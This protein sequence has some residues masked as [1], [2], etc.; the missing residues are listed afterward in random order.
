MS[1]IDSGF[2]T[3]RQ[4][5]RLFYK[6]WMPHE[7]P[8]KGIVQIAHGMRESTDYYNEFCEML[9][10]QGYGAFIH[11]AR[12]HGQTAGSPYSDD[13]RNNAGDIGDN[14]I[15]RMVE[16][17]AEIN[18]MLHKKYQGVPVFLLGHSMGSVLARLYISQYGK[19]LNGVI[20]S[21]TAALWDSN[22]L[23]G[24]L[25]VAEEEA[26][27][28]GKHAVAVAPA[29]L[30]S[31]FFKKRFQPV[32]TGYEYMSRDKSMVREAIESPYYV[33]PYRTGF[34]VDM[35]RAIQG[36][37]AEEN[38]ERIPKLLPIFSISGDMDPFGNFG[39]GVK[40]LFALYSRHGIQNAS[41]ILYR[42]GRHEML[43]ET[44]RQDVFKDII[45]WLNSLKV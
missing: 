30:L 15:G 29:K 45:H 1:R 14:G 8:P 33:V 23:A 21:G 26:E 37:D 24:M 32:K 28:L 41:F 16:D 34:F 36:M 20:F 5:L 40:N 4:G 25:K 43:R 35:L 10:T 2:Y 18:A 27:Q 3:N 9:I 13:F 42:D 7:L 31:D 38:I 11:D 6:E 12:G 39:E 44:N 22:R 19:T 17:L